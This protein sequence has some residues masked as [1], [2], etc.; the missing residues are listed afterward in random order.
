MNLLLKKDKIKRAKELN[1]NGMFDSYNFV[2]LDVGEKIVS[3]GD[4]GEGFLDFKASL[5]ANKVLGNILKVKI[6]LYKKNPGT[7]DGGWKDAG[8][9]VT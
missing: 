5:K 2:K 8:G 3:E 6:L 7:S 4:G 1:R 9:E